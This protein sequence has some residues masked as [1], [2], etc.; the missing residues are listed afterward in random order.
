[1]YDNKFEQVA[2]ALGERE[3]ERSAFETEKQVMKKT[4]TEYLKSV[5]ENKE[6]AVQ[7]FHALMSHVGI[8]EEEAKDLKETIAKSKKQQASLVFKIF[9]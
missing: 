9:T 8:H 1:M 3:K 5:A 7:Y 6:N 2:N 4:L